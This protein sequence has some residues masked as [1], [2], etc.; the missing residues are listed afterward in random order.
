MRAFW[1]GLVAGTLAA[2]GPAWAQPDELHLGGALRINLRYSAWAGLPLRWEFDT[3]RLDADG[4]TRGLRYSAEYRFYQGY[5]MLHHGWLGHAFSER[6]ELQ[7]GIQ[8]VPFGLLPFASHNWFFSLPYYLGFEDDYD[9]GIKL[10]SLAPFGW[11]LELHAAFYPNDEGHFT[12]SSLDSARYSYDV[13]RTAPGELGLAAGAANTEVDQFDLRLTHTIPHAFGTTQ[14]GASGQVGGLY[15]L[16]S[17]RMGDRWAIALHLEGD[18]LERWNLKL[19]GIR[20][21][22]R[23]QNPPGEDSRWVSM[24][25][26]DA[27]YLVAAEGDLW[28]AGLA[29]RIP[30]AWGPIA[31]VRLYDDFSWLEKRAVGFAP[32]AMN[33]LGAMLRAGSV[34]TYLEAASGRNHPWLGADYGRALA[35]GSP[36]AGW[37]TR[38][39]VNLGVYF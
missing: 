8:R 32:S 27:P 20:Y 39:N 18:Y 38:Y 4:L 2:A 1:T 28:V 31:E 24:G 26:Y 34:Y 21:Q 12:G 7:L 13:V 5:H 11:P 29:Y 10:L 3:F 25:A 15:N 36:E 6:L 30:V 19:E 16:Q 37:Q 14:L 22:F 9:T 33:V 17:K 23:P 35:E